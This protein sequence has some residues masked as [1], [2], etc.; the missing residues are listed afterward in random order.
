MIESNLRT[1][2]AAVALRP[3][4]WP[5]IVIPPAL[6]GAIGWLVADPLLGIEVRTGS[7]GHSRPVGIAAVI[8]VG[9]IVALAGLGLRVLL[10]A[11]RDPNRTWTII[12]VSVLA[13]SLLGP[14][15]A[16]TTAARVAL[17]CLHLAVGT[18]VIVAV[19]RVFDRR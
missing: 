19:R 17:L 10:R 13:V 16:T 12:A 4:D 2:S 15:G 14:L 1:T 9:I 7:A 8:A 18:A 5:A 3:T 6:I 11:R